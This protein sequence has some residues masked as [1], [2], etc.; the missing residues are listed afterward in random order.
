MCECKPDVKNHVYELLY[1][2]Y[3][4]HMLIGRDK[5]LEHRILKADIVTVMKVTMIFLIKCFKQNFL[6]RRL[7]K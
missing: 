2:D 7:S 3:Y 4:I 5:A 6:S 1:N